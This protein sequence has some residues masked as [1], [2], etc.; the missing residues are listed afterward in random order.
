MPAPLAPFIGFA[1]GVAFAWWAREELARSQ[2]VAGI[3]LRSLVIVI[4]FATVHV[5]ASAANRFKTLALDV[6]GAFSKFNDANVF[7]DIRPSTSG[8][9]RQQE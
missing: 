6:K 3:G 8:S 4:L 9:L 7:H 1:L 5:P 2:S